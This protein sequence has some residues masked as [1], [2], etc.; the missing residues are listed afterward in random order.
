MRWSEAGLVVLML[1]VPIVQPSAQA[2]HSEGTLPLLAPD[3]NVRDAL[4]WFGYNTTGDERGCVRHPE[5]DKPGC[6]R[7][8]TKW[9]TISA[10]GV[11]VDPAGWPEPNASALG[12]LFAH[13]N[14]T[15][16]GG[17]RDC[18]PSDAGKFCRSNAVYSLSKTILAF[19]A[20]GVDPRAVPLP[21]GGSRDLVDDILEWYKDG[22]FGAEAYVN[23]DIF[24]LISLNTIGYESAET[25]RSADFVAST[26]GPDGGVGFTRNDR[27]TDMVGAS[28]MAMAPRGY[29][30]FVE[31]AVGYLERRQ[32]EEGEWRAC[33]SDG[34][35]D[36]PQ[37]A[38]AVLGLLA[39]GRDPVDWQV[40]GQTP[41]E[42]ILKMKV[43]NSGFHSKG[44]PPVDRLATLY[45]L[46][47]LSWVPYGQLTAPNEPISV[48]RTATVNETIQ[49]PTF[50]GY[51]RLGNDAHTS[52]EWTPKQNGSFHFHGLAYESYPRR[53]EVDVTVQSSQADG[54]TG[55]DGSGSGGSSGGSGDGTTADDDPGSD[56][57]PGGRDSG[58]DRRSE[59][60]DGSTSPSQ[61]PEIHDWRL[62][63][64]ERNVRY[65]VE[66]DA[67]PGSAPLGGY[68]V[69]WGD[70][71]TSG[72]GEDE[73]FNHTYRTLGNVSVRAWA[74]DTE[75]RVSEPAEDA[76]RVVDASPRIELAGP[77]E[78]NRTAP[79]SFQ[80]NASDPDGPSPT[81]R[82]FVDPLPA[83]AASRGVGE[84]PEATGANA[85]LRFREPG[86]TRIEA[87]ATDEAGNLAVAALTA[88]VTNQPPYD[89]EVWPSVIQ[90]NRAEV[91]RAEARDPESDPLTFNWIVD[92]K[93][94]WGSQL[95]LGDPSPGN[96]TIQLNVSDR[97]G[98][99]SNATA[100]VQ[101][102]PPG[103]NSSPSNGTANRSME[104][105]NRSS[106]AA[107]WNTSST[108]DPGSL[109]LQETGSATVDVPETV[110]AR[111]GDRTI[112]T[113]TATSPDGP[114]QRVQ[115]KM[116]AVLPVRGTESFTIPLPQRPPGN[117]TVNVRAA[118]DNG[119]WGPWSN[120]T[121]IVEGGQSPSGSGGPGH[122]GPDAT[123]T[124]A[125]SRDH[126][127]RG[128]PVG[129]LAVPTSVAIAGLASHRLRRRKR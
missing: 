117:Y 93:P 49:L 33:W 39:A 3:Q 121:V 51:L 50:P 52:W 92:G 95:H 24:A 48:N 129:A 34:D 79:A 59:A 46:H 36:V 5:N 106:S 70:G 99:W 12:W 44:E 16:E 74:R 30:A 69:D 58:G 38:W 96:V 108:G 85:T 32:V 45:A 112:L 66:I 104:R 97:Y 63:V 14:D 127:T 80:A 122:Q 40:D 1:A 37:T 60:S 89:V 35:A 88:E 27:S 123:P 8:T 90:A 55:G 56:T 113:G 67:E 73:R 120:T 105:G 4:D 76:L 43:G 110:R 28:I 71:T 125:S 128:I 17:G 114:I 102:R 72:W 84:D 78:V 118:S 119:T 101:V 10:A 31:D 26:Q 87:S 98:A 20:G 82:W 109:D 103:S 107:G 42:C 64:A 61:A 47:A 25:R 54:S 57:D 75:G 83:S 91:L 7:G 116:G 62:G 115:A 86:R 53:A 124:K 9:A 23:D 29:D 15:M 11:G 19:A 65:T 6:P 77:D 18:D 81:I 94:Y 21:E 68:K 111:A 100:E 2:T 22:Q 41:H 126:R 13:A